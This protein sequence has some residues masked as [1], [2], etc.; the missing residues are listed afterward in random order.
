MDSVTS[1]P[2]ILLNGGF[3]PPVLTM[4]IAS[5]GKMDGTLWDTN[6]V[7][8]PGKPQ[9]IELYVPSF[10][11]IV[12][13]PDGNWRNFYEVQGVSYGRHSYLVLMLFSMTLYKWS[14]A[15]RMR[16]N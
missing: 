10:G 1:A 5:L 13:A 8:L 7:E 11:I 9:L 12:P 16:S 4:M 6:C 14:R 2:A 15:G 3:L